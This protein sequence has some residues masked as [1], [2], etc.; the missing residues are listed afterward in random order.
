MMAPDAGSFWKS[1]P[2]DWPPTVSFETIVP[3]PSNA[4]LVSVTEFSIGSGLVRSKAT[5]PGCPAT[6]DESIVTWNVAAPAGA[7]AVATSARSPA[8]PPVDR[9]AIAHL[10]SDAFAARDVPG[11]HG[12]AASFL[13]PAV[14]ERQRR[15]ALERAHHPERHRGLARDAPGGD[16]EPP[17]LPPVAASLIDEPRV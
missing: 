4:R 16:E 7:A 14:G 2:V 5:F 9:L 12:R 8:S 1:P 11:V 17:R 3:P 10:G 13:R 6:D 15:E